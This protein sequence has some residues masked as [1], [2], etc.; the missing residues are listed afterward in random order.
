MGQDGFCIEARRGLTL[1]RCFRYSRDYYAPQTL[2]IQKLMQSEIELSIRPQ[3][4]ANDDNVLNES[5]ENIT[6]HT[7]PHILP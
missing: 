7:S 6:R 3:L 1:N 5:G 2:L 4:H